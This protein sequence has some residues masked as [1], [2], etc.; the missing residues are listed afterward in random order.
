M[1]PNQKPN[2]QNPQKNWLKL[3]NVPSIPGTSGRTKPQNVPLGIWHKG[4]VRGVFSS[5]AARAELNYKTEARVIPAQDCCPV[6][7]M[8]SPCSISIGFMA[9]C[10]SSHL[11]LENSTMPSYFS[12]SPFALPRQQGTGS[13]TIRRGTMPGGSACTLG[14]IQSPARKNTF[15]TSTILCLGS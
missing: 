9:S 11:N 6:R 5:A 10:S 12:F 8:P 15:H 3:N 7:Y 4:I 1:N 14:Q 2:S 13:P